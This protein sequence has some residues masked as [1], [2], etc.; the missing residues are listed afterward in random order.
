MVA[1]RRYSK[2]D[3]EKELKEVCH[4]TYTDQTVG[5]TRLWK[6]K[7]DRYVTVTEDPAGGF[8]PDSYLDEIIK[9]VEIL[10]GLDYFDSPD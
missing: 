6:T 5:N 2:E 4:L 9:Q 10:T 7:N 3:F 8:Y 1:M